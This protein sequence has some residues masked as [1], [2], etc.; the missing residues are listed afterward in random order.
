MLRNCLNTTSRAIG[1]GALSLTATSLLLPITALAEWTP[2]PDSKPPNSSKVGYG[3]RRG[4]CYSNE[5]D[6]TLTPLAP[7]RITGET[8]STHPTLVWY[9]PKST[10]SLTTQV[11]LMHYVPGADGYMVLEYL[12]EQ[13]YEIQSTGGV[14]TF[15]LP[16]EIEGLQPGKEYLWQVRIQCPSS[17][18]Y[19][20]R[21]PIRVVEA[22]DRLSAP[23]SGDIMERAE[24]FAEAGLW[25]DAL[26]IVSNPPVALQ[27][28]AYA[29]R[30]DLLTELADFEAVGESQ[31]RSRREPAMQHSDK[32]RTIAAIGLDAN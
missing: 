10:S 29:F 6:L 21:M 3:G 9:V 30:S 15:T 17:A 5:N 24:Q 32:L 7:S 12:L 1:I 14:E 25:Y 31:N 20:V 27:A 11:Q 8:T 26:A 16:Q 2:H 18:E 19:D 28:D 22:G 23:L 4:G 13:P